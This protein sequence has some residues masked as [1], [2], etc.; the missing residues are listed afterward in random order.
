MRF[1]ALAVMLSVALLTVQSAPAAT[2]I[3]GGGTTTVSLD[4]G[5]VSLL[6]GA[7]INLSPLGS[8]T[9]AGTDALFP[10]T[11]GTLDTL[12][13]QAIVEHDGSGLRFSNSTT[14]DLINFLINANVTPGSET[15]L[16]TG[17]A[18]GAVVASGVP[19]FNVG[20]GL[21][22]TLRSEAAGALT[23]A[24]GVPDLTGAVVGTATVSPTVVPEPSSLVLLA[25]GGLALAALRRRFATARK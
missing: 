4:P 10:I 1:F 24:F 23:A 11:G 19:L 15:G 18:M 6:S 20:P 13:N 17:D 2:L 5:L 8:A 16:L 7:G 22:L 21:Q 25:S 14:L 9:I 12:S 3:L